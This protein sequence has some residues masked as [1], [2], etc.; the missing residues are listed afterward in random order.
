V[1]KGADGVRGAARRWPYRTAAIKKTLLEETMIK[2]APKLCMIA[3]AAV[4]FVFANAAP[5]AAQ[6]YPNRPVRVI[7]AVTPGGVADIFM[8]ALGERLTAILKQPFIME[9]RPGGTFNIATRNCAEATPDGY[10]ICLLP[11]EPLTYNQFLFKNPGFNTATDFATITNLFFITQ[12]LAVNTALGVRDFGELAKLSKDKPGTL[13]YT[14]PSLS[15]ATFIEGFKKRTGAD[16]VGVPFKGGGD[17]MANFLSGSVPVVFLGLGNVLPY[18][19]PGKA[20]VL[21]SDG[22]KRSPIIP[23]V[24]TVQEIFKDIELTRAYFGLVAPAKTPP[25][26]IATLHRAISEVYKDNDFIHKQLVSRGL[27]PALGSPQEY[28]DF[29]I[30]DRAI[31]ERIVKA[32]GRQP[33]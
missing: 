33:Q 2:L 28:A 24:P 17:A 5:A 32:S 31:A 14:A 10:T 22:D 6:D 7:I 21:A 4:H 29:L 3:L 12:V 25:E 9:N 8:R 1:T 26:A 20:Q 13:S 30:K 18:I 19:E 15:H 11:G 16:I 23:N 27:D